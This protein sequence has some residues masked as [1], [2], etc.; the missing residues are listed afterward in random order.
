MLQTDCHEYYGLVTAEKNTIRKAV[1]ERIM[2]HLL[3]LLLAVF[4]IVSMTIVTLGASPQD[5]SVMSGCVGNHHV[6]YITPQRCGLSSLSDYAGTVLG[7][8][9]QHTNC[10]LKVY[11]SSTYVKCGECNAVFLSTT[12][13]HNCA[14][15][16]NQVPGGLIQVDSICPYGYRGETTLLIN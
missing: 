14:L 4:L 10:T 5:N 15:G 7:A 11:Y 9:H 13:L 8:C 16:H 12:Y 3:S 2:K 1:G 6:G